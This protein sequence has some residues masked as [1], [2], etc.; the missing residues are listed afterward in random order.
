MMKYFFRPLT[1]EDAEPLRSWRNSQLEF[2]RQ[3]KEI[4]KR[5]QREYFNT[6][7]LTQ[8]HVEQPDQYLVGMQR[9]GS[10]IAYGGLTR[11]SW[12]DQRGEVSFLAS[13]N[14]ESS[15][16]KDII[17]REFLEQIKMF[18]FKKVSLERIFAET[19]AFR[20][21]HIEVLEKSG[22]LFEGKLRQHVV[23]QGER[24]D[25]IIHGLLKSQY[26]Q[27]GIHT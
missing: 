12:P 19:Y 11:I 26:M 20:K 13:P 9:N 25:S 23:V 14:V 4:T 1:I 7:V 5:E 24:E 10:L 15:S 18:A 16:E 6:K 17:F 2:L 27:K 8:Y 22:F 21:A 3:E